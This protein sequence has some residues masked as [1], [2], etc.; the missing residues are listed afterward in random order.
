MFALGVG[1]QAL[2]QTSFISDWKA[3][4][5][6]ALALNL[7]TTKH[8][9]T[10]DNPSVEAFKPL[11]TITVN[12]LT[13]EN[14][15]NGQCSLREAI[16][17]ANN[18]NNAKADCAAGSGADVIVFNV[19]GTY[20]LTAGEI[21]VT[22]NITIQEGSNL[23]T[24]VISG[25]SAS[26]IFNVST[27]NGNLTLDGLTVQEGSSTASGGC[28]QVGG[29]LNF[30]NGM[31]QNC[32]TTNN[33]GAIGTTGGTHSITITNSTLQNN[34]S[35]FNGGAI[36]QTGTGSVLSISNSIFSNN[37]A[38]LA[39]VTNLQGGAVN[40]SGDATGSFSIT[41]STFT[42]NKAQAT[43]S[44][45]TNGGAVYLTINGTGNIGTISG[46]TFT[47]NQAQNG[48]GLNNGGAIYKTGVGSLT[49]S[50][51]NLIGNSAATDGGGIF[52]NQGD[53]YVLHSTISGNSATGNGGG[54]ENVSNGTLTL[55][56]STVSGNTAGTNG[57]GIQDT[58]F[59]NP[60]FLRNCT[61]TNNTAATGGGMHMTLTQGLADIGNSIIAGNTATTSAPDYFGDITSKG[62]NLFSSSSGI[63][64]ALAGTDIVNASPGLAALANNGG[65]T[66]THA[67][68]AGCPAIAAG[69]NALA[70]DLTNSNSVLTTDQR[71]AGFAR[72]QQGTVDIGAYESAFAAPVPPTITCPTNQ[73]ATAPYTLADFTALTMTSGTYTP[74]SVTQSPAIGTSLAVGTHTITMTATDAND[75]TATCTF[76]VTVN[77]PAAGSVW[78]VN[79]SAASGGNGASWACGFQNLQDAINAASSG[80]EIWVK[81]GT[82]KPT[83]FPTDCSNCTDR[84]KT[85]YLKDGVAVYG[86]FVGTETLRSQRNWT[87]NPTTLSGDIGT[88]GN[89]SDNCYHVVL[90]YSDAN[91]TV[92]DGFTISGGNA[93][94]SG[95]MNNAVNGVISRNSGGGIY[96]RNTS[97]VIENC[98]ISANLAATYGAGIFNY[99]SPITLTNSTVS[100][101]TASNGGGGIYNDVSSNGTF[102]GCTISG[103]TANNNGGGMTNNN[104]S[105]TITDCDFLNNTTPN[106][107]GGMLNSFASPI[108]TNCTF[109]NNS[110]VGHSGGGVSNYDNFC[111]P[112]FDRCIFSGN[113]ALNSA[114]MS[115][116]QGTIKNC[117]FSGNSASSSYGALSVFGGATTITNCT[118]S[119]NSA[120]NSSGGITCGV[121]F[122]IPPSVSITNCLIWNNRLNGVTGSAEAN[123]TN[124]GSTITFAHNLIQNWN[125]SGT[126]NLN[127]I[128]NAG[129]ANYPAFTTPLDPAT[130]PST[131]GD[132]HIQT[133]SPV[134]NKGT[135]TGAPTTDLFGN[136]RPFGT[137]VD[138]GAHELQSNSDSR[139]QPTRCAITNP[140]ASILPPCRRVSAPVSISGADGRFWQRTPL[141][142]SAAV[143]R[144]PACTM[145]CADSS[146]NLAWCPA[147][148]ND[149]P[150]L[151]RPSGQ[152][153]MGLRFQRFAGRD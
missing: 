104:C 24:A 117:I 105:P 112:T 55:I 48:S 78:Y 25:N 91:T 141:R 96:N 35:G 138:L 144:L 5:S 126:G 73:T 40:Y 139:P 89:N 107:G 41:G 27:T 129:N 100:G 111:T 67:L 109:S 26:R 45:N 88:T 4:K 83:T 31:L 94:G 66:Q 20:T 56:N 116:Y 51:N 82:Y 101:N 150:R 119:G 92:L 30:Q 114:G 125:P 75:A 47:N 44:T 136:T 37:R 121:T 95:N 23:I 74:I 38:G 65:T 147:T 128:A 118:F 135:N 71:G 21:S 86:G 87:T 122:G 80:H 142:T 108:V 11:S 32:T 17:N 133:C 98:I 124:S 50:N 52:Q 34:S 131:A 49:T 8:W 70:V 61:I 29:T 103:N 2:A 22:S 14:I 120:A 12:T 46:S 54:I 57:G 115:F 15:T 19:A 7:K 76:S 130:A 39:T 134:V 137:T 43:S 64:S 60:T 148:G 62:Y 132:F 63:G 99:T 53:L 127:G 1:H 110:A 90:S 77:C 36:S 13:D 106:A 16:A 68:L 152:R 146:S 33:G 59:A 123:L 84:D 149:L 81:T 151:R 6:N 72:I 42:S 69:S 58:E 18:D 143:E 145:N 153:T 10:M 93:N 102:S 9:Y 79:P 140:W 3:D 85:F 113:T 97:P 28:I